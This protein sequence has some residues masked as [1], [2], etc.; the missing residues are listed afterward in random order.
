MASKRDLVEAYTFNRR[1]L[2]TAFVSGAP[3]GREVEPVRHGRTLVGG[4]VLAVLMVGG[5]ALSGQLKPTVPSDWL[6]SGVVIGKESGA[7]FVA[8]KGTLYP[9]INTTSA[10]LLAAPDGKVGITFAPD[11]LIA[12]QPQ[13]PTIGIPGAP[14]AL[15]APDSLT[16]TGWTACADNFSDV[17]VRLAERPGAAN[18]PHGALVVRAA[19]TTG[20][21]VVAGNR[22]YPVS[23]Q[24]LSSTLRALGLDGENVRQVPGT[25]LD[26]FPLGTTLKP[27][28]VPGAGS[29]S[30]LGHG[31]GQVG[32]PLRV[33]GRPYVVARHGIVAL[34][35]FS[36]AVYRSAGTGAQI[37]PQTVHTGDLAGVPSVGGTV[38]EDW[39][40]G[41]VRGLPGADFCALLHTHPGTA[42][43]VSLATPTTSDAL[44]TRKAGRSASVQSGHG[45]L[46]HAVSGGV[47]SSD[48]NESG[49]TLFLIDATGTRYAV[50]DKGA[51]LD[52]QKRLGYA[53]VT[54]AAVPDA[55]M[56]LFTD[57]PALTEQAADDL[58]VSR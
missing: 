37:Q 50:G 2:V 15:P 47:M 22:R 32:T 18:S 25:W 38:P 58:A 57:G 8:F 53:D 31:L 13:G 55:W 17:K 34:N 6:D 3:G 56:D 21:F 7:R 1:R 29:P 44:A 24:Y 39:P 33:D 49:N 16:Q 51:S 48:G 40:T 27:F 12:K 10:R 43:T 4:L 42:A 41:Q 45:A 46:V 54:P 52:P 36:Y 19:G 28:A 20:T 9:I 35:E 11:S 30:G 23:S 14:D 5:A 26:L